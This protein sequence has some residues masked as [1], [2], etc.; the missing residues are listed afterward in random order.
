MASFHACINRRD[1]VESLRFNRRWEVPPLAASLV[2]ARRSRYVG[3]NN[4]TQRSCSACG[5]ATG[6][7]WTS[8]DKRL[9]NRKKYSWLHAK[10]LEHDSRATAPGIP[11]RSLEPFRRDTTVRFRVPFLWSLLCRWI[12]GRIKHVSC[13][14]QP[15]QAFARDLLST[16]EASYHCN[17]LRISHHS[18][19]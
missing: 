17:M 19:I 13:R 10:S 18:S 12:P 7:D 6:A 15:V 4:P 5:L 1:I 16:A 2:F 14:T 3:E 9:C 8:N 11:P